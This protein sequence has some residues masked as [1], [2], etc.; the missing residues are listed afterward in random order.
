MNGLAIIATNGWW[1]YDFDPHL[2]LDQSVAWAQYNDN[3]SQ[4]DA[5]NIHGV[6]YRDAGYINNSIS[7]LQTYK[8]V[9][10][11]IVVTHT[12]PIPSIIQ[13]DL[14]LINSWKFNTMGNRYMQTVLPMDLENKIKLWCFGHYHRPID[15][16]IDGIRYVSNPRDNEDTLYSQ[17]MYY[18]KR[19]TIQI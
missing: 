4:T 2:D 3:M 13:H 8:D 19:I 10:S 7:K 15:T 11:I 5:I 18:P 6:S 1:S 12:V 14:E 16:V 17:S 9:K